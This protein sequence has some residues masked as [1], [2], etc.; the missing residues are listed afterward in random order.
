VVLFRFGPGPDDL[1][2]IQNAGSGSVL[3]GAL[4]HPDEALVLLTGGLAWLLLGYV[5][6]AALVV[7]GSAGAGRGHHWCRRTS[8]VLIPRAVRRVLEAA[9]GLGLAALTA[10]PAL[11]APTGTVPAVPSLDRAPATAVRLAPLPAVPAPLLAP[12]VAPPRTAPPAP[13][14][15]RP[16]APAPSA[17][18]PDLDRTGPPRT[19]DPGLTGRLPTTDEVVV[20]RGD[21]LWDLVHR[22]LGPTA[23]DADVARAWPRWW[24][25]NRTAIG[26]DPDLL[27]PG[28]VLAP[29]PA[30]VPAA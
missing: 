20:R 28:T 26:D 21:C 8:R 25:H 11:A 10:T 16:R 18:L 4:A 23:N 7:L 2:R 17:P 14:P 9:L 12:S 1:R 5:A 13:A 30:A 19:D 3:S 15:A 29:P 6:L 24:A 27:L 22:S